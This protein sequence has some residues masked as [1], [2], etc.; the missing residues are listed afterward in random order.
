MPYPVGKIIRRKVGQIHIPTLQEMVYVWP[1]RDVS[2]AAAS[3]RI[4]SITLPP[5]WFDLNKLIAPMSVGIV[6]ADGL[7][8]SVTVQSFSMDFARGAIKITIYNYGNVSVTIPA[9]SVRFVINA[10][11]RRWTVPT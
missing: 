11:I 7:P 2:I 3:S 10:I 8:T 1:S 4:I 5:E 6:K 9:N